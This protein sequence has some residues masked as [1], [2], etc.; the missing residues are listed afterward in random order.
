MPLPIDRASW[1]RPPPFPILQLPKVPVAHSGALNERGG[2]LAAV[3]VDDAGRDGV[4]VVAGL[5]GNLN[6]VTALS[7]H[8]RRNHEPSNNCHRGSPAFRVAED[9]GAGAVLDFVRSWGAYAL[10][11]LARAHRSDFLTRSGRLPVPW[12]PPLP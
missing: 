6:R 5:K 4:F 12:L 1:D 2:S 10:D 11:R 9:V 7:A 3:V 8:V